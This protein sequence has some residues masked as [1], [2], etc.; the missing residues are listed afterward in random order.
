VYS[1]I[2]ILGKHTIDVIFCLQLISNHLWLFQKG[3]QCLS[4]NGKA[5][6]DEHRCYNYRGVITISSMP[7]II[8]FIPYPDQYQIKPVSNMQ[9]NH[10]PIDIHALSPSLRAVFNALLLAL[11]LHRLLQ[12][13][14]YTSFVNIN[15]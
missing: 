7:N 2:P 1:T 8:L 9:Y 10:N 4:I 12:S 13:I 3:K 6:S 5:T 11:S 14:P 15:M